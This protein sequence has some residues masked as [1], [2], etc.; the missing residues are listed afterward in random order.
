MRPHPEPRN[1]KTQ[2]GLVLLVVMIFILLTTLAAGSMVTLYQTATQRENEEQ[3]LFVGNQYRHAIQSY[4]NTYPPGGARSL[5]RSI[6]D[7]LSD[8]RFPTP[9]AHLRRPYVDPMTGQANWEFLTANG[10]IIGIHSQSQVAPFKTTG[11]G[12]LEGDFAHKG[13]YSEWD[14]AIRI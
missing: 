5:P 6:N 4:Y 9:I 3:L 13:K 7:L 10:G 2:S 12:I 11:F 1:F 8:Q 14:F